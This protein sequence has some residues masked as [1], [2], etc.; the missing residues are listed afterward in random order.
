MTMLAIREHLASAYAVL[1]GSRGDVT[2]HAQQRGESRQTLYRQTAKVVAALDPQQQQARL[3]EVEQQLADKEL[4][5]KELR[6]RLQRAVE[7]TEDV[8]AEFATTAQAE[9]VS[10]PVARRLLAIFL[11][12]E[13]PSVANLGRY[14]AAA[15]KCAGQLLPILDDETR[16]RVQEATGDEIFLAVARC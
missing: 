10:L 7:I 4:Q 12:E 11:H 5:L 3:A 13:T 15:A 1:F 9:G 8:I 14:S 6:Q 2:Q 16:P